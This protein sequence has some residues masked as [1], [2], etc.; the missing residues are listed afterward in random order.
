MDL[1]LDI[2]NFHAFQ[3]QGKQVEF[4]L[5]G[6]GKE[7]IVNTNVVTSTKAFPEL[8]PTLP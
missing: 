6:A 2:G 3:E 7:C 1:W 5:T 4:V 8:G